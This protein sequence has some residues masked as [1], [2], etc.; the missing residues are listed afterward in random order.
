M[1]LVG[2]ISRVARTTWVTRHPP[3]W[4]DGPFT[5]ARGRAAVALVEDAVREGRAPG[6]VVG[7]TGL[8]MTPWARDAYERGAAAS[9]DVRAADARRGRLV[10]GRRLSADGVL[11]ATGFRAELAHLAPLR[12]R[13]PGGGIRLVGTRTV[14]D[15]R[16]H[17]VGYGPSAST[18]GAGR[19]A[20]AAAI[21]VRRFLDALPRVTQV[22]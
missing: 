11:W 12:L 14:R 3:V 9:A 22:A 17:L 1:Q 5:P 18:L 15:P 20:R 6:S 10:D 4:Q 8:A 19:A 13:E 16:V 7:V 2:E 21:E